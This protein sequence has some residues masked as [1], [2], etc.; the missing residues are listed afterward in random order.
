MIESSSRTPT[1]SEGGIKSLSRARLQQ[2]HTA[3]TV[4]QK[5]LIA[6]ERSADVEIRQL[7][8]GMFCAVRVR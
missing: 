1:S 5:A 6:E 7:S 8:D 3:L 2:V 4:D